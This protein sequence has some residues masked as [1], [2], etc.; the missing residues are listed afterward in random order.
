M[1]QPLPTQHTHIMGI[2]EYTYARTT[3]LINLQSTVYVS[4]DFTVS[5]QLPFRRGGRKSRWAYVKPETDRL[6]EK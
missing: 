6:N 5:C 1:Y 3:V 2:R 4:D